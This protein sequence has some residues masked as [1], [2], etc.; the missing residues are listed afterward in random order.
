MVR[1]LTALLAACLLCLSVG[2]AL[3]STDR[4]I[5][6]AGIFTEDEIAAI[7]ESIRDIQKTYQI[8]AAVLTTYDV[9]QTYS[10]A[11]IQDYADLY[12]ERN[13]F[14]IG[15][16]KAGILYMIDMTNRAPVISTSGVMI[17]YI[18]DHRLEE[19][20][21]SAYDALREGRYG[22]AAFQIM[23]RTRTY[24]RQGREEG[25]FRYD[26]ET[27]RRLTGLYN[28]LTR[29]ELMLA[30]AVGA[31]VAAAVY[32]AVKAKYALHI[33]TY[34]Y[35]ARKL[36][37]AEFLNNDAVFVR[38]QTRRIPRITDSGR[39]GGS[40]GSHGG[41]LGSSVHHSS[42]GGSHGGGVGGRF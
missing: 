3:A 4:V 28:K 19:L 10:D 32:L 6:D 11:P 35:D 23:S 25:S 34:H 14:G 38:S 18:T 26:A 36:G 22:Q 29:S 41:G 7:D 30:L 21:D 1:K 24:L 9:P 39:G 27:G 20:F 2:A 33:N 15:E 16:D 17:D 8:D 31:G 37:K 5:D 40:G 12:Y 13:G 42:S